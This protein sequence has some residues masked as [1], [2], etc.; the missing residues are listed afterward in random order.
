MLLEK[1]NYTKLCGVIL[2]EVKFNHKRGEI[3]FYST[4]VGIERWSKTIDE[5]PIII[6][7]K[8]LDSKNL[9][10]LYVDMEGQI[11]TFN[12]HDEHG[13]SHLKV[14]F[15]VKEIFYNYNEVITE[16]QNEVYLKGT[17]CNL[18]EIRKTPEGKTIID[19]ILAVNREYNK[20][21]YIPCIAWGATARLISNLQVGD[22]IEIFGRIQS[23]IYVKKYEDSSEIKEAYEVSVM[24]MRLI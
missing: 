3:C 5:I 16:N 6:P 22:K 17:I 10:G 12:E 8:L 15:F 23:R 19:F 21:D 7:E 20:A 11:R 4:K 13:K 2:E 1:T 9:K 14:Y 18:Q 24:R